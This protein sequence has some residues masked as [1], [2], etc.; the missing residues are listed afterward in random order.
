M[1]IRCLFKG[2]D[3]ILK[4]DGT[5]DTLIYQK[6]DRAI[7]HYPGQYFVCDCGAEIYIGPRKPYKTESNEDFKRNKNIKKRT[8]RRNV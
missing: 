4:A 1:K 7:D 5:K 3:W 2:H 6:G 8:P